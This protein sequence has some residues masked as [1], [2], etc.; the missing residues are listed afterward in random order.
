MC[1]CS[2]SFR[3]AAHIV[4][5]IGRNWI[6]RFRENVLKIRLKICISALPRLTVLVASVHQ[7]L[8]A[9]HYRCSNFQ[10]FL[11]ILV[12]SALSFH[13]LCTIILF[14]LNFVCNLVNLI[15]RFHKKGSSIQQLI[16]K[17]MYVCMGNFENIVEIYKKNAWSPIY[18]FIYFFLQISSLLP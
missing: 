14:I 2:V 3:F 9:T 13:P 11:H 7:L 1:P 10:S 17:H 12:D 16:I 5:A 18:R 8:H 15:W 6:S 4:R